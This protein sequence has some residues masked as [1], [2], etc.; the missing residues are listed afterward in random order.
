MAPR[1]LPKKK[2]R[3]PSRKLIDYVAGIMGRNCRATIG[4]TVTNFK[5]LFD[6]ER[7]VET[8]DDGEVLVR[9]TTL[10]VR[11]DIADCLNFNLPITVDVGEP[12]EKD[13]RIRDIKPTSNGDYSNVEIAAITKG[14]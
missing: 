11:R 1:K 3:V 5:A 9:I 10:H 12:E 7:V 6:E 14:E 4:G 2:V 8:A 13:Y